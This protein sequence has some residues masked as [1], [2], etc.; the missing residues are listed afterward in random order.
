MDNS[1]IKSIYAQWLIVKGE[2]QRQC[3]QRS[4]DN[5]A[6]AYRDCKMFKGNESIEQLANLYK[7]TQ[8]VEFCM[9][10]HFPNL[11]TL[12]TFKRERPERFGIYIDAGN[13]TLDEPKDKVL[14]IGRTTAVVNCSETRRYNI[15]CLHGGK[16]VVNASKWAVVRV[17]AENG[18]TVV[19]NISDNAVIL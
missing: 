13:I 5:L 14:L 9:R 4:L 3:E 7:S 19:R 6:A 11:S 15:V 16:A 8:G 17:E 18:T 1:V 10:Y 2:A 12:R